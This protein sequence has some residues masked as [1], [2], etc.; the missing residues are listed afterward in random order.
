MTPRG[1]VGLI[2]ALLGLQLK[3]ISDA[4]YAIV[5]FMTGATTIFAPIT[6]RLLYRKRARRQEAPQYD[7]GGTVERV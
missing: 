2:I 4:A 3:M 5:I 6:L 1:E 7:T